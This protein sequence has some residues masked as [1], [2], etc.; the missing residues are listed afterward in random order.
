VQGPGRVDWHGAHVVV[1]E[2][3]CPSLI[4]LQGVV[5]R[6][7]KHTLAI[8]DA[9]EEKPKLRQVPKA[10]TVLHVAIG[11]RRVVVLHAGSLRWP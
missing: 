5:A 11:A 8:V 7:T 9:A 4:G 1:V 2:A 10:G 3:S 6:E